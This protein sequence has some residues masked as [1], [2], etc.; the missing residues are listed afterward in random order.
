MIGAACSDA[1]VSQERHDELRA[2]VKELKAE[3]KSLQRE[4]DQLARRAEGA[5]EGEHAPVSAATESAGHGAAPSADTDGHAAEESD[6]DEHG[7]AVQWTY[8]GAAGPAAWGELSPE[9]FAC[10]TGANQSP[11]NLV[12]TTRVSRAEIVFRYHPTALTV[13]NNGHTLQANVEPGGSVKSQ[14]ALGV[15]SS[16]RGRGAARDL[17]A[18]SI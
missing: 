5:A 6:R 8:A 14:G 3:V 13:I 18:L 15:A 1:G 16:E 7:G 2:D 4:T 11:I 10:S 12:S 9:F 17:S